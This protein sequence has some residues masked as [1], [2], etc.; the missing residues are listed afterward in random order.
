MLRVDSPLPDDLEELVKRVI[1]AGFT[2]HRILG[3]GFR[4]QIYHAAFR[5]EL[6][7]RTIP[8]ESEKVVQVKYKEWKLSGQKIDGTE[9]IPS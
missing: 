1:D 5:L 9:V 7:A 3:P 2:V 8:F 6:D 4:E